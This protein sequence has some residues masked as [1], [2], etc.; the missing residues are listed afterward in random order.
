LFTLVLL[1]DGVLEPLRLSSWWKTAAVL[2]I[3]LQG[4]LTLLPLFNV[5]G[6]WQTVPEQRQALAVQQ[7]LRSLPQPAFVTSSAFN[8]PWINPASPSMVF[9]FVYR[10]G[11]L[12]DRPS[13]EHGIEGLIQSGHFAS[14]IRPTGHESAFDDLISRSAYLPGPGQAEFTAFVKK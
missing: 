3:A 6:R 13:A 11:A 4:M 5:R 8:L 9:A 1:S 2:M 10:Q 12:S 14:I 7:A